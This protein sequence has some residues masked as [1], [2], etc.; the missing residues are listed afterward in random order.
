ME[1]LLEAIKKC[2]GDNY[3]DLLL[4]KAKS[5]FITPSVNYAPPGVRPPCI[6]IKDGGAIRKELT[7]GC[8]EVIRRVHLAISV[9]LFKGEQKVIGKNDK[10]NPKPGVLDITSVL[11]TLLDDNTLSLDGYIS[12]FCEEEAESV[13]YGDVEKDVFI[14]QQII[15]Y[16]YEWE[17]AR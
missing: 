17:G 12:A 16:R 13:A 2:L 1:E 4:K 3:E 11:H 7:G 8:I 14:Q 9:D 15:T 5:V 6:G 10:D